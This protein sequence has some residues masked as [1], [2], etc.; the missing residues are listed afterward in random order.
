MALVHYMANLKSNKE[1]KVIFAFSSSN[2]GSIRLPENLF[3]SN[4]PPKVVEKSFGV[5]GK[6]IEQLEAPYHKNTT[7]DYHWTMYLFLVIE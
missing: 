4:I 5:S 1:T 6:V 7:G 2:P 3:G